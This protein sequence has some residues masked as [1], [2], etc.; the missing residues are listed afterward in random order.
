MWVSFGNVVSPRTKQRYHKTRKYANP[1]LKARFWLPRGVRNRKVRALRRFDKNGATLTRGNLEKAGISELRWRKRQ[2]L[3]GVS[4]R[5]RDPA[6]I[7]RGIALDLRYAD[8]QLPFSRSEFPNSSLSRFFIS[9]VAPFLSERRAGTAAC[10]MFPPVRAGTAARAPRA[11]H[12]AGC[13]A[14]V[15]CHV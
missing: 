1:L 15:T 14:G 11:T 9:N 4:S 13:A 12:S 7:L 8:K 5:Q 3:L 6:R 2:L 10:T